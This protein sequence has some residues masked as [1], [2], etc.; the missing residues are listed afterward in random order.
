MTNETSATG[1]LSL[2]ACYSGVEVVWE[3]GGKHAGYCNHTTGSCVCINGWSG[4]SEYTFTMDL[5]PY[6][7]RVL[8]CPVHLP[9]IQVLYGILLTVMGTCLVF[10]VA[11]V[12]PKTVT[13][14]RQYLNKPGE[15][16]KSVVAFR[17][18]QMQALFLIYFT[19]QGAVSLLKFT[20]P[21]WDS[22][23][24]G[25][26][27]PISILMTLHFLAI[28]TMAFLDFS[29]RRTQHIAETV[30]LFTRRSSKCRGSQDPIWPQQVSRHICIPD[31]PDFGEGARSTIGA[32]TEG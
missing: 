11:Y 1:N 28:V 20:D 13:L 17:P 5:E 32:T 7:G 24:Y 9:T 2:L 26:H 23:L 15:R 6:G 30:P 16:K 25:I 27:M 14:Y 31:L 19:A 18:C 4:R 21:A 12:L 22:T 3:C 10:Q 29:T 8:S